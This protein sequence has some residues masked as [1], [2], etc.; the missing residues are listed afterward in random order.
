MI[1]RGQSTLLHQ[2]RSEAPQTTG[3]AL[4]PL[5]LLRQSNQNQINS[6]FFLLSAYLL[7][8]R[9]SITPRV[10]RKLGGP[11]LLEQQQSNALKDFY[12]ISELEEIPKKIGLTHYQSQLWLST[13]M[14]H[15]FFF[16]PVLLLFSWCG[17]D[18]GGVEGCQGFSLEI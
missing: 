14:T 17:K 15:P 10:W 12:W 2:L 16:P 4:Q 9:E 3:S 6:F 13:L 18:G 5:M 8:L 7:V 11:G 1:E